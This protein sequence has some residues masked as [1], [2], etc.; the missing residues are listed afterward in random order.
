MRYTATVLNNDGLLPIVSSN[1]A[2]SVYTGTLQ[3][4][5][6]ND[7][8][9][10]YVQVYSTGS[11]RVQLPDSPTSQP[12][13]QPTRQP[14]SQPT[15]HPTTQPTTQ[16]TTHP[17]VSSLAPTVPSYQPSKQRATTQP[18]TRFAPSVA[19]TREP[20]TA[21]PTRSPLA[22]DG[23]VHIAF[24]A[25]QSQTYINQYYTVPSF[26]NP[27]E[28]IYYNVTIILA[29]GFGYVGSSGGW[30]E[31]G[32]LYQGDLSS[33]KEFGPF[34]VL[35]SDTGV[36]IHFYPYYVG[37]NFRATVCPFQ[38]MPTTM[39]TQIPAHGK[40]PIPFALSTASHMPRLHL[41]CSFFLVFT[42]T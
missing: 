20:T 10:S 13:S 22:T 33:P 35:A 5:L 21:I 4:F 37:S 27:G 26:G 19:P 39:P 8:G 25:L 42:K 9:Y 7:G 24:M 40:S 12:T 16:P 41:T 18:T 28:Q 11:F 23:C 2:A 17:S 36:L 14:I 38:A 29:G 1:L 32:Q 3:N 34:S 31:S 30:D 15:S 6:Q